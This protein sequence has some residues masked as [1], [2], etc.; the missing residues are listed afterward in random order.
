MIKFKNEVARNVATLMTGTVLAQAIPIAVSPILTRLYTPEDFGLFALYGA[1]AAIISM[2]ATG[3]YEQAIMLPQDDDE[4]INIVIFSLGIVVSVSVLSLVTVFLFNVELTKL[5]GSDDISGWLYL[6]PVSI[7][8]VGCYQNFYYWVN[9]QKKYKNIAINRVFQ[10]GGTAAVQVSTAFGH[11]GGG[12]MMGLVVGQTIGLIGLLQASGKKVIA[13][14]PAVS[15]D[16]VL[17]SA[18]RYKKFPLFDSMSSILNMSTSHLQNIVLAAFY[19]AQTAGLYSLVLRVLV[20]PLSFING[21]LLDVLRDKFVT[22]YRE[23][24]GVKVFYRKVFLVLFVLGL[25]PML[26]LLLFAEDL[27]QIVFGDNW[28]EAGVYASIL[29]PMFYMR[30]ISSPLSYMFFVAEKQ[31]WDVVGNILLCVSLVVSALASD[32]ARDFVIRISF[33]HGFVYFLYL[34]VSARLAKAI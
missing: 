28:L 7:L 25:P 32:S 27:F 11:V 29:A 4:A 24:G 3:R 2:L 15:V 16:K 23:T 21:A 34:V 12:L 17:E 9:R 13:F 26:L 14:I 1:L 8:V 10:S 31:E 5:L 33:M 30:F 22:E 20:F 18:K 19:G 6:L